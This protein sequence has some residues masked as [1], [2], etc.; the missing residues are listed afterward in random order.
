MYTAESEKHVLHKTSQFSGDYDRATWY[1]FH[2]FHDTRRAQ[3]P[4]PPELVTNQLAHLSGDHLTLRQVAW[5]IAL[6]ATAVL[7]MFCAG[8][9]CDGN[10][11]L[12]QDTKRLILA[13]DSVVVTAIRG[14]AEKL[15]ELKKTR[16]GEI[17]TE[18]I[19]ETVTF[20]VTE[21]VFREQL[22][23]AIEFG[24]RYTDSVIFSTSHRTTLEFYRSRTRVLVLTMYGTS[25]EGRIAVSVVDCANQKHATLDC[26]ASLYEI[27]EK[28]VAAERAKRES[29]E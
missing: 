17:H 25:N 14:N 13:S 27:A 10:K 26:A 9:S 20:R 15:A 2:I 7:P 8:C 12:L 29:P 16:T 18:E 4:T 6:M 5:S 19:Q 23:S 21:E 1:A 28:K 3:A 24:R 11:E 22:A